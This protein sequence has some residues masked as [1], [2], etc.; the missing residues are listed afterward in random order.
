M[1]P[2]GLARNTAWL[3]RTKNRPRGSALNV[4][5]VEVLKEHFGKHPRTC[6]TYECQ[7]LRAGV[8]DTAGHGALRRAGIKDFRFHGLR[9]KWASWHPQAGTSCDELKDLGGWKSRTMV[10]PYAKFATPRGP[11]VCSVPD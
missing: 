1:G 8:A 9:H 10:D 4:D 11:V 3:N 7:P 6:F 2:G 5:A